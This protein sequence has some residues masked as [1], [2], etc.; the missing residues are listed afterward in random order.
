M[1]KITIDTAV[2]E[3]TVLEQTVT[4]IVFWNNTDITFLNVSAD[5]DN[6]TVLLTV[7][8]L[9]ESV[10][11]MIELTVFKLTVKEQLIIDQ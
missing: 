1:F 8:A 6:V 4:V 9:N 10:I 3:K 5:F 7:K 11:I 2:H